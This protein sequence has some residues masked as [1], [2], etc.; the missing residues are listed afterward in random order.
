MPF[1]LK[2]V[3]AVKQPKVHILMK[4]PKVHIFAYTYIQFWISVVNI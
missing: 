2:I 1:P 4:Q 3:N